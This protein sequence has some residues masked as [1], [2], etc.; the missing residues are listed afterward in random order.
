MKNTP[1]ELVAREAEALFE[2]ATAELKLPDP[3][4]DEARRRLGLDDEPK[5]EAEKS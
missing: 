2:R 5:K 4:P 3:S 1:S